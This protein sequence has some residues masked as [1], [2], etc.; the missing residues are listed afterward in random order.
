LLATVLVTVL[1]DRWIGNDQT[2]WQRMPA[3]ILWIARAALTLVAVVAAVDLATD[4]D[5]IL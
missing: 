5:Q 3:T 4:L 1:G 2:N